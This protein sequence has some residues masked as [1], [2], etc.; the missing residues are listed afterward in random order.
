[1]SPWNYI[2]V[3][4]GSAGALIASR[5]TEDPECHVLLIEAGPD[6]RAAETPRE[7]IDRTKGL[8]LSLEPPKNHLNPE[9]YWHDITATRARGQQPFQYRRG[10]GLGGSSTINGL[11]AIRGV[12]DDFTEWVAMGAEGWG[13][14]SM[15]EAYRRIEDE[16]DF[17]DRPWHGT[18]GPTPIYREPESGWGGVDLALRDAAL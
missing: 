1:M 3:G 15:L 16:L 5:L 11:Y 8:G 17:P 18:G 6:Y 12:P 14:H 10:K 9:F 13:P 4:G 2:V 7:F